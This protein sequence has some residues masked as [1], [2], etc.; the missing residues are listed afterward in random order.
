M[1]SY[2]VDAYSLWLSRSKMFECSMGFQEIIKKTHL[3]SYWTFFLQYGKIKV[4]SINDIEIVVNQ[5]VQ[6]EHFLAIGLYFFFFSEVGNQRMVFYF[7]SKW[8]ISVLFEESVTY[9]FYSIPISAAM[10]SFWFP[11]RISTCSSRFTTLFE[12]ISNLFL[13]SFV[14]SL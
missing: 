13:M 10:S 5:G 1:K 9:S 14:T 2:N 12:K 7:T 3:R 6:I 11:Y 4:N 8:F